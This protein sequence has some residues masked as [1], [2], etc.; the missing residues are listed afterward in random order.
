MTQREKQRIQELH[1]DNEKKARDIVNLKES[2]SAYETSLRA[3]I[4][5]IQA[6]GDWKR[7]WGSVKL[8][9]NLFKVIQEGFEE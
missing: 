3:E 4:E 8:F 2:R 9:A 6:L 7:F 1:E 5:R